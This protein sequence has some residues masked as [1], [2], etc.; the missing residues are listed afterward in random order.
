MEHEFCRHDAIRYVHLPPN[1]GTFSL[2]IQH[3]ARL[4]RYQGRV[5]NAPLLC[6]FRNLMLSLNITSSS[7]IADGPHDAHVSRN[8]ATTKYC[9]A[10]N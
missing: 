3:S 8:L 9:I 7:A 1:C 4:Q 5:C 10:I 6:Y 2:I